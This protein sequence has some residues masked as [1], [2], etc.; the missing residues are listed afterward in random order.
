VIGFFSTM[1]ILFTATGGVLGIRG[2]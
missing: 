1:A 2:T